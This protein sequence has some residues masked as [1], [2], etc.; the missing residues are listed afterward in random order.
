VAPTCDTFIEHIHKNAHRV[1][2]L[3]EVPD[4]ALS[5]LDAFSFGSPRE[6]AFR[7]KRLWR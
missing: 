3:A 7:C 6:V 5:G 1:E 4:M 2:A